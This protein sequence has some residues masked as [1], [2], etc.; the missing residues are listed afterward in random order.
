[1]AQVQPFRSS[2][3]LETLYVSPLNPLPGTVGPEGE[4][5]PYNGQPS[6]MWQGQYRSL[7][8]S[9]AHPCRATE[10]TM[11]SFPLLIVIC[12]RGY[13]LHHPADLLQGSRAKS[14][15]SASL[16]KGLM[17]QGMW[18]A[19]CLSVPDISRYLYIWMGVPTGTEGTSRVVKINSGA[20]HYVQVN[21]LGIMLKCRFW[22]RKSGA[23]PEILHFCQ[24]PRW[25]HGCRSMS[26]T[27]SSKVLNSN[28]SAGW[29]TEKILACRV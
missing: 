28:E 3:A 8:S 18:W 26:H 24:A 9:P 16:F 14:K 13:C 2:S 15:F 1:M 17:N 19:I 20:S 27:F 12:T 10:L 22:Y 11:P 4:G 5:G 7:P 25:G 23:W 6:P 29:E 21:P